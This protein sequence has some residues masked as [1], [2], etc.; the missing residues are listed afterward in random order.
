MDER[1]SYESTRIEDLQSWE[2][3]NVPVYSYGN[4]HI[5]LNFL[6]FW[7][8]RS[9]LLR[10]TFSAP[11]FWTKLPIRV[12]FIWSHFA[13]NCGCVFGWGCLFCFCS[14]CFCLS[15]FFVLLSVCWFVLLFVFVFVGVCVCV[16]FVIVVVEVF[17][18]L[19]F[20]LVFV[21]FVLFFVLFLF[22]C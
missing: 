5:N 19:V 2:K 10:L 20:V 4:D 9:H 3:K 14:G 16:C 21:C 7:T 18:V 13:C 1:I 12:R 22:F 8:R 15:V 6:T 17:F 11:R